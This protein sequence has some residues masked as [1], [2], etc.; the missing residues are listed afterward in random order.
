MKTVKQKTIVKQIIFFFILTVFI[1]PTFAN[2]LCCGNKKTTTHGKKLKKFYKSDKGAL[3][4]VRQIG[5][6]V[7][8][9]AERFDA[10]FVAVFKGKIK[11][12]Q[13]IGTYYNLPKG[14][15]KGQ[16]NLKITI[17]NDA[18]TLKVTGGNMDGQLLKAIALPS[19]IPSRRKPFFIGNGLNNLTGWWHAKNAGFSH[20]VDNNGTIA[21]CFYGEQD[22]SNARPL[23]VKVFFGTRN[24]LKMNIEW[25]DL[26]I[27]LGDAN[28][29]GHA[30]F[31]VIGPKFIRVVDGYFPGLNHEKK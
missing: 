28:C 17:S 31:K 21:G 10:K 4:Y 7:Y 30:T 29:T 26:P 11:G 12:N 27:G 19:R 18:K 5:D 22:G 2:E 8:W 16:G 24:K 23:T 3:I 15:V 1:Q 20:I 9:L 14:K 25:I 6:K 13:I